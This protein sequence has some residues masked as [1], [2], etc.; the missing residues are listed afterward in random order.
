ML[1]TCSPPLIGSLAYHPNCD[2][3]LKPFLCSVSQL[4]GFI[5]YT[6]YA[7]PPSRLFPGAG[8]NKLGLWA[9]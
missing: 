4:S 3:K 2:R 7:Y 1:G 9:P 5:K 6:V 8:L